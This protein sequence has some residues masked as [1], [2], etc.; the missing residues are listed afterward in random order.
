[1]YIPCCVYIIMAC[2]I[3]NFD[4]QLNTINSSYIIIEIAY[5][6]CFVNRNY[7]PLK[8]VLVNLPI[9]M[10]QWSRFILRD[11]VSN[12]FIIA[13]ADNKPSMRLVTLVFS[14][15]TCVVAL[16]FSL[17]VDRRVLERDIFG[18]DI[19]TV[20]DGVPQRPQ[21]KRILTYG[22]KFR[23]NEPRYTSIHNVHCTFCNAS[24]RA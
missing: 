13:F 23:S 8:R 10:S 7:I 1:M 9:I 3:G 2:S 16:Y 15:L 11:T 4:L 6:F 21:D 19:F 17:R 5:L 14:D 24:S 20:P 12:T 18:R 22:H